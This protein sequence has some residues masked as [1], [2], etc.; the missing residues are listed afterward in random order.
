MVFSPLHWVPSLIAA[1]LT[2]ALALTKGRLPHKILARGMILFALVGLFG[3]IQRGDFQFITLDIHSFH[4]WTGL[5]TF[6]ISTYIFS[7]K[8][9]LRKNVSH[10]KLGRAAAILAAVT[11]VTGLSMLAGL[12]LPHPFEEETSF[13]FQ[14]QASSDLP[15]VEAV[16][17][18][19]VDLTPLSAQRNNAIAGTQWIDRETYRLKVT[20][21]VNE[22]IEMSYDDL[23]DLPAYSELVRMN[24]VE[25]WGFDAKWTGFR[26]VDLLDEAGLRPEASYVVFHSADGYSSGLD[27]DYLIEGSILM[28]YGINDV[29]LP[30][31]RG[32]PFQVVARGKYG[33]KWAKWVTEIEVVAEERR[34]FWESRGYSNSANVGEF[35]FG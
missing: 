1:V 15:G 25:G 8:K 24:C 17:Y 20:G 30:P 4:S 10:C 2:I 27:L 12:S 22:E 18:D 34:G 3:Y 6:I 19:G 29:T 32:F 23:L 14:A 28:A 13:T 26:V 21:L 7:I 35:P 16:E 9:I 33:Y 31:E 5:A 11:L